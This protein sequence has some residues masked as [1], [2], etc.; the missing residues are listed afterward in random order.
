M[1]KIFLTTFLCIL[2][3]SCISITQIDYSNHSTSFKK[4]NQEVYLKLLNDIKIK[5]SYITNI[6]EFDEYLTHLNSLSEI[7]YKYIKDSEKLT[8]EIIEIEIDLQEKIIK[9]LKEFSL[10]KTI[11]VSESAYNAGEEFISKY[12][13]KVIEARLDYLKLAL[14][15]LGNT[16][17]SAR[18]TRELID[19]ATIPSLEASKENLRQQYLNANVSN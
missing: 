14:T 18:S 12:L 1:K 15:N 7:S 17:I 5:Y 8:E 10:D 11:F 6:N 2:L 3:T 9:T 16:S 19:T 13:L 4:S